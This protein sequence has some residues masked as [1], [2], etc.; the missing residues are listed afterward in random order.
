MEEKKIKKILKASYKPQAQ[1][2]A[3]LQKL[4]YKYD[5]E[6]SS[7]ENKVFYDPKTNKPSIGYRGSTTAKDWVGNLKLG[8]GFRD[9]DAEKRIQL[10]DQVKQKYG[11]SADVFGDSRGGYIAE[12][13]GKQYGG[14]VYTYNKAT[15]PEDIFSPIRPEQTDIRTKGDIVSLPSYFQQGGNKK[16]LISS[17]LFPNILSSHTDFLS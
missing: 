6:L 12:Q 14:N 16:E 9:K 15:L 4:G 11:Q 2:E 8:L 17:Q 7:M 10:A 1:A 3:D 5:H 13:A